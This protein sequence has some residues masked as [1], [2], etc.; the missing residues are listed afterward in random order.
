MRA[1][2][3]QQFV[4]DIY[5]LNKEFRKLN[6]NLFIEWVPSHHGIEGNDKADLLAKEAAGSQANNSSPFMSMSYLKQKVN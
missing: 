2:P 1:G 3:G 4:G 5:E 6:I